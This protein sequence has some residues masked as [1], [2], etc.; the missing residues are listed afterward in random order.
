MDLYT[1]IK[2]KHPNGRL[3]TVRTMQ[4]GIGT[5]FGQCANR[6][7]QLSRRVEIRIHLNIVKIPLEKSHHNFILDK[8]AAIGIQIIHF[9]TELSSP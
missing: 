5:Y 7:L 1:V 9:I 2:D 6:Y 4:E 3:P 8:N